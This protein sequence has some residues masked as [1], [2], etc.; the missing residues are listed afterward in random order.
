MLSPGEPIESNQ[1]WVFICY[2]VFSIWTTIHLSHW[3][4]QAQNKK[5]QKQFPKWNFSTS[6]I[7]ISSYFPVLRWVY[8]WDEEPR[9]QWSN[10]FYPSAHSCGTDDML[11]WLYYVLQTNT[12]VAQTRPIVLMRSPECSQTRSERREWM[13]ATGHWSKSDNKILPRD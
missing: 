3:K 5:Q 1:H 9:G 4:K 12:D 2:C 6:Q 13:W 10:L 11:V 7:F 8:Q